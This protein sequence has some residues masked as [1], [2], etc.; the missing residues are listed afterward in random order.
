MLGIP[1]LGSIEWRVKRPKGGGIRA[2][3]TPRRLLRLN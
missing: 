2:L 1:V 3:M